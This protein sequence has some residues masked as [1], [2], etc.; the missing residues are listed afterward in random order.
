MQQK[1]IDD[2]LK[3][4]RAAETADRKKSFRLAK[5]MAE[6]H[7]CPECSLYFGKRHGA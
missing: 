6:L 2:E 5:A 3:A 1:R 4:Y 7:L